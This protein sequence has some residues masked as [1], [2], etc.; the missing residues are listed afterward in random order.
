MVA[1]IS[2]HNRVGMPLQYTMRARAKKAE[3]ICPKELWGRVRALARRGLKRKIEVNEKDGRKLS[4]AG[5]KR[6]R[7][8]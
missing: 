1:D 2:T 7:L 5:F 8:E 4:I 6:L 3:K